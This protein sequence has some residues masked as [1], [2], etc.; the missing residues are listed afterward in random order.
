LIGI[1]SEAKIGQG[2]KSRDI[3]EKALNKSGIEESAEIDSL[4]PSVGFGPGFPH[5]VL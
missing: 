4:T 2:A 3:T 1:S 5:A